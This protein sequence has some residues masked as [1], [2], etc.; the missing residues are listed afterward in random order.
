MC[1]LCERMPFVK[2]VN[3]R[4]AERLLTQLQAAGNECT[5]LERALNRARQ[6]RDQLA[7][8]ATQ[9]GATRRDVAAAAHI[10][11]GRVQQLTDNAA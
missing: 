5:Q 11:P 9:A 1:I 10:S 6:Q 3:T 2:R 7:I 4:R 8:Q